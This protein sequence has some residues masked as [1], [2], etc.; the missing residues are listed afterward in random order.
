MKLLQTVQKVPGGTMVIPLL[1]GVVFNTFLPNALKLGGL[2]TATFS[3]AGANSIMG[4]F[5]VCVG[6]QIRLAQAPE[7]LKRGFVLLAAKFFAGA[8][9]GWAAASLFGVTG[10]LGISSLALISS[11]TNSNGGLFMSLA[12]QF[13]DEQ[14]IGAQAILNINDGPFLTLVALGA[15]GMADIPFQ[16]LLA[17][18]APILVG[19]VLGN[20]DED[21]SNFFKPALGIL[22]P[23]FAF[24]LGAGISLGNLLKAGA[25]GILLGCVCIVWS[26]IICILTDK[27]ILRR[28]GYAGAAVSSAAG[29]CVGTPA[30]VALATAQFAP[31]IIEQ[32]TTQ[33]A[34]A[35]IVTVI[36]VPFLTTW[37]VKRWGTAAQWA[38]KKKTVKKAVA[39]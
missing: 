37:A 13:G 9:L 18:V 16:N 34:A 24:C 28:P 20:L 14:D 27:F 30:A 15:S 29:N 17:A 39:A 19:C 3:S 8:S 33:C 6:S 31:N 1:L 35:V 36:G 38:E 5:L 7:V 2:T 22:I 11:V 23:F 21:I 10:I 32:A 26:G 12:A 25:P 4:V